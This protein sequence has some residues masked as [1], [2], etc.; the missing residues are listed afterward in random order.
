[1]K[2][3]TRNIVQLTFLLMFL[4]SCKEE[5][6]KPVKVVKKPTEFGEAKQLYPWNC[7]DA[8]IEYYESLIEL[9]DDSKCNP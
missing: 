6:V 4:L 8:E 7:T 3:K 2:Y 5:K 9:K 1:M